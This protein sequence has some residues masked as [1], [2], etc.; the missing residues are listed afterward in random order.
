MPVNTKFDVFRF[1]LNFNVCTISTSAQLLNPWSCYQFFNIA[2]NLQ[3]FFIGSWL[4]RYHFMALIA[5][6]C[7]C[8]VKHCS[9]K[10]IILH[11]WRCL[12]HK[13][14][15][16]YMVWFI[17]FNG[18]HPA[19]LELFQVLHLPC[20]NC[21]LLLRL[22]PQSHQLGTMLLL[23]IHLQLHHSHI[24]VRDYILSN[25]I[26]IFLWI[27]DIFWWIFVLQILACGINIIIGQLLFWIKSPSELE[28]YLR[29]I[30]TSI[31][32]STL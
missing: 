7:R 16:I 19:S 1:F 20:L 10:Q 18:H 22:C 23:L 30:C 9:S 5:F 15:Q 24:L 2:N 11:T 27:F 21:L 13:A 29:K 17:R 32:C 25:I 4:W 31:I 26:N 28:L 3:F 14:Y 6:L 8:A 12:D